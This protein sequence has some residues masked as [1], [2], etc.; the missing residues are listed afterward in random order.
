LD[1][2]LDE[3]P[4]DHKAPEDDA[5]CWPF[6]Q[7]LTLNVPVPGEIVGQASVNL[8][9]ALP[10]DVDSDQELESDEVMR[11]DPRELFAT[12]RKRQKK[13]SNLKIGDMVV[14]LS[15][16]GIL[17]FGK[18][19]ES[20]EIVRSVSSSSSSSSQGPRPEAQ[21]GREKYVLVHWWDHDRSIEIPDAKKTYRPHW[22][23][24]PNTRK[25]K[26]KSKARNNQ[27]ATNQYTMKRPGR[28]WL[29]MQDWVP[30]TSLVYWTPYGKLFNKKGQLRDARMRAL[31]IRIASYGHE[32]KL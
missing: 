26:K 31:K 29:A 24:D 20:K 6:F 28:S 3:N 4:D 25:K 9:P 14:S 11:D 30:A 19:K 8:G 15:V 13:L 21:G 17:W 5:I 7:S 22:V 10:S 23:Q 27:D 16:D 1:Q 32:F 2:H 18:L 12:G